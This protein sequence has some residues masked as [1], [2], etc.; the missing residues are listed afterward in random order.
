MTDPQLHLG[1]RAAPS[2]IV[3]GPHETNLGRGR[4]FSADHVAYYERRAAGGV[5]VIVTEEA[6]VHPSDWP[7]ERCPAAWDAPPGWERIA[8]A[9][10]PH[11]SLVIAAL[12]HSGG[13]GSSAYSQSALW[14][15]SR[16]P[17]VD[18]REVPKSMEDSDVTAVIDAF[19]EASA[20]AVASGCDGVEINIGQHSLIRQFLSGLTNQRGD[21]WADRPA[22]AHAVLTG[23]R[24]AVGTAVVGMRFSADEMA[25]WAGI[26]PEHGAE[27]A[28][29]L[30][31]HVDYVTVVRGSIFSVGATRPDSHTTAGFNAELVTTVRSAVRDAHG[32]RVAVLGQGSVVDV[33][34]AR[35]WMEEGRCDGVEMTRA[36]IAD[37]ALVATS[38]RGG[39]PRPCLLCNQTCQ[40]RD[41]RNPIITCVV[42]PLSGHERHDPDPEGSMASDGPPPGDST[43]GSARRAVVVMGAGV[44]GLEAARVAALAGWDVEVRERAEVGGMV[45]VASRAPGRAS[46]GAVVDWLESECRRL[47]VRIVQSS[48]VPESG[49]VI[50]ATGS[51][52]APPSYRVTAAATVMTAAEILETDDIDGP[53]AVWDPI[54]GPIGVSIAETL[55]D[56]V[57][58]VL[59]TPDNIVGNE[60][61]RSGD[62]APANSRLAVAGVDLVKRAVLRK[63]VKA[64]VEVEDRFSGAVQRIPAAVLVDAGH[65]LPDDAVFRSA[66]EGAVRAGDCV[67]P[68]TIAEAIREGRS[69]ALALDGRVPVSDG[70][71]MGGHG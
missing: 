36:L 49:P 47:G 55:A 34:M 63:V 51:I 59:I 11:G 43:T 21:R 37:A 18:T 12:G 20:A 71:P 15:P 58:V 39:K 61:S 48:V 53:V 65:R 4:A 22:F 64:A 5:G 8:E 60:L 6:S 10:H 33:A 7:Y 14:A 35:R 26:V 66:P 45:R 31:T 70:V 42:D 19:A 69:A 41:A 30:A 9:V 57:A 62:L 29:E 32:D 46:L 13:Q 28:A 38:A 40:V 25:P 54:G 52:P 24:E 68:R 50:V 67:A 16:V 1:R 17:E 2:P 3:F 44:A 27:L 23:V 56:K